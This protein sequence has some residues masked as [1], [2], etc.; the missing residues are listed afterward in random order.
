MRTYFLAVFLATMFLGVSDVW[1]QRNAQNTGGYIIK[2]DNDKIYLNL[3]NA[4]VSDIVSVYSKAEFIS[5]RRAG[6]E[7]WKD[8]IVAQIKIIMVQGDYSVGRVYG[9]ATIWPEEGMTVRKET[10]VIQRDDWGEVTVMIA[11]ADLNFPKGLNNMVGNGYGDAGYIG[12]YVSAALMPHILKS[13]KIQ[14]I[15]SSLLG[16][17]QQNQYGDTYSNPAINYAKE[18][19]A[20]YMV[21]VTMLKPD[22][23]TDRKSSFSPGKIVGT[24]MNL[25]NTPRTRTTETIQS[26]L[27]DN[28]EITNMAVSVKM[29]V[30]IVDLQTGKVLNAWNA[31]GTASGKPSIALSQWETYGDLFIGGANFT[32]TVTGRAIDHA[33]RKIGRELNK[34]FKENL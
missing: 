27:P 10:S 1:A 24:G 34:Y 31:E 23:V 8:E 28:M 16:E 32:Q 18:M 2:V 25:S 5:D 15:D 33:F 4:K 26:V 9:N 13:G 21:K 30:H 3:P 17:P 29:V 14:L 6:K 11:P 7:I 19:G 20:R 12:D 22:V